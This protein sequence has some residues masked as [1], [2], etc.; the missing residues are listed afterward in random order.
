M[1]DYRHK[2]H[3]VSVLMSPSVC[4]AQYRRVIFD[5]EVDTVRKDVCFDI[6]K[7]YAMAFL[8][9]GTDKDHGHLLVQSV[10]SSSP[11]KMV[12]RI[13]GLTARAIFPRVPTVTTRL[14]GGAFWSTG[15]CISPV[16]RHGNAAVMRRYV[17][18]QGRAKGSQQR[19]RQDGPLE[20]CE[21]AHRV[22]PPDTPCSTPPN[23][24]AK[25]VRTTT[26]SGL[27]GLIPRSLL[28][29]NSL[30]IDFFI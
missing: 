8:A 24:R 30:V 29:G 15:S 4:P 13:T 11:T 2:R 16:G 7:R 5:A 28:R 12:T 18:P 22:P 20:W 26:V 10:P 14:G 23:W 27:R 9:I 17:K 3:N 19:H 21:G 6:A 25:A 1:S